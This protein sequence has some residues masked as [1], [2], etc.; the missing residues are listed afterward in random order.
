MA[1]SPVDQLNHVRRVVLEQAQTTAAAL[2]E[3]AVTIRELKDRIIYLER[4]NDDLRQRLAIEQLT[5]G[6]KE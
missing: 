2:Q 1:H 5:N 6:A 3:G 4:E